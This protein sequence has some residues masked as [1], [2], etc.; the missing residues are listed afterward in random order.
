MK[1]KK[2]TDDACEGGVAVAFCAFFFE[3]YGKS[4]LLGNLGSE[5]N[6]KISF[7]HSYLAFVP[8]LLFRLLSP[9]S[10]HPAIA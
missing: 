7:L 8:L 2:N 6:L 3:M 4:G 9:L 1:G 5:M 10:F